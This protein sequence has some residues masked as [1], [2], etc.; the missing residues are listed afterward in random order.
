MNCIFTLA[1]GIG[2]LLLCV[3]FPSSW[4]IPSSVFPSV[5]RLLS[6]QIT[7]YPKN[8]KILGLLLSSFVSIHTFFQ[9]SLSQAI[10]EFP[11]LL[12][13]FMQMHHHLV[14]FLSATG[15]DGFHILLAMQGIW[16]ISPLSCVHNGL[17]LLIHLV[18]PLVSCF[19]EENEYSCYI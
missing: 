15:L 8:L 6:A 9:K 14:L 19:R 4:I 3:L 11:R 2:I 16:G 12:L 17:E 18:F 13:C 7:K 1:E 10:Q 5:K